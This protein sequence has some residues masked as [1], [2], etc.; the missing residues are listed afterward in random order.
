MSRPDSPFASGMM[1]TINDDLVNDPQQLEAHYLDIRNSGFCGVAAFV[2]CSRYRWDHPRVRRTLSRISSWCR[3]DALSFWMCPDP[4]FISRLLLQETGEAMPVVLYGDR[5]L[6]RQIPHTEPVRDGRFTIRCYA[7]PR[8]GH[9]VHE[10]AVDYRPAGICR[11]VALRHTDRPI[12]AA[13]LLDLTAESDFFYNARDGYV[14]AFGDFDPPDDGEWRVCAFF[15]F[16]TCHVDYG[17]PAHLEVYFQRLDLLSQDLTELDLLMWDEPGYTCVYGALPFNKTVVDR[18]HEQTRQDLSQEIWKLAFD[19]ADNSHI[20]VR[21]LYYTAL[22][23]TVV[24]A[25]NRT[26]E[27]ARRLWSVDLKSGIHETWHFE[28]GDMADRAHGSLDLWLDLTAKSGGFVDLGGIQMLSDPQSDYYANLAAMA[29]IG[30]SLA[31]H[32]GGKQAVNNL[33]TSGGEQSDAQQLAAM[34]QCV[35]VMAAFAQRWLAHIY[36]P[37]GTI[38]ES[39]RFLGSAPTPGYPD[40]CTW[41]GFPEWNRRLRGHVEKIGNHLP[42]TNILLVFPVETLY[43]TAPAEANRIAGECF[44]LILALTDRHY[45]IDV[46]S[47]ELAARG[48]WQNG[49]LKLDGILY[50]RV[51]MPH[52]RI[53][54]SKIG[55]PM[56]AAL[57]FVFCLPEFTDAGKAVNSRRWQPIAS[58]DAVLDEWENLPGLHPVSAP[59]ET[60]VTITRLESSVL[61]TLVPNRCGVRSCGCV[62]LADGRQTGELDV[63][64]LTAVEFPDSGNPVFRLV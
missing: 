35:D 39:D 44:R 61:V 4:R 46:V 22:R 32:S 47:G 50:N 38:G 21:Q 25:Q 20:R 56:D 49:R 52:A 42:S 27:Y 19:A 58:I 24:E 10:V 23:R 57:D 13:D 54:S 26:M 62:A 18:F 15:L 17:N 55:L 31:R 53:M 40:H 29:V 6:P 36:G 14:E 51:V 41:Q 11:V 59:P 64:G 43:V 1:W 5:T 3:R 45:Q 60:W 34:N 33:W 30:T 63:S 48:R 16:H 8:H 37:V 9:M 12:A 2:R 28:S 7:E